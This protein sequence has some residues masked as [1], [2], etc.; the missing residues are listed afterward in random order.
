MGGV[1]NLQIVAEEVFAGD[2]FDRGS[3]KLQNFVIMP[4][5]QRN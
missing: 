3:F 5:L 2:E 1:L 4:E